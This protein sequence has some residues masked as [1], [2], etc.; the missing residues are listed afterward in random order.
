M[1]GI[2]L[3]LCLMLP[4][5]AVA[6][7]DTVEV[8]RLHAGGYLEAYYGLDAGR[9]TQHRRPCFLYNHHRKGEVNVN[10]ALLQ[11]SADATR[12]R[13]RLG[14]MAGTYAQAN[15]AAEP[16]MLRFLYET[17]VGMAIGPKARTWLDMGVFPSFYGF[18][19]PI[20]SDNATLSRSLC[21]EGSPYYLSGIRLGRQL[22]KGW[23]VAGYL[24][25]GWQRIRMVPGNSLPS[26]GMQARW[27]AREGL[28]LN[29]STFAGTDDPDSTR[30]MRLFSNLYLQW[31]A[32]K[33]LGVT[34]GLDAGMQQATPRNS[35]QWQYWYSPVLIARYQVSKRTALVGRVEHFGDA[36]GVI[37]GCFAGGDPL[38]LS[39][40]SIGGDY[41]GHP[42]LT[43]RL[44][45][46]VYY[47]AAG[48]FLRGGGGLSRTDYALLA[49]LAVRIP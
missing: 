40:A 37:M 39:G 13:A 24:L 3:L 14:L 31:Q 29:W 41:K 17:S 20:G 23:D 22:G 45:A 30:R 46:K 21:A 8:P 43:A 9:P 27:Q 33:R 44:E 16:L 2:G 4:L 36:D 38:S 47:D 11:F 6:Q 18:E 19:S 10:L 48:R 7:T 35:R 34:A 32:S 12:F 26:L 25:N 1:R 15:L 28:L 5:W 42:W 49:A